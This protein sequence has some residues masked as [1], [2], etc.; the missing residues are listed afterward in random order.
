MLGE[1]VKFCKKGGHSPLGGRLTGDRRSV[2]RP[3]LASNPVLLAQS[4]ACVSDLGPGD[5]VRVECF[6][7][8]QVELLTA[9]MLRTAGLPGYE[10][11]TGLKRR[12]CRDA[13]KKAAWTCRLGGL[14]RPTGPYAGTE[15]K[16][17]RF[18]FWRD[19]LGGPQPSDVTAC[20]TDVTACRTNVVF[21][22]AAVLGMAVLST[23]GLAQ[24]MRGSSGGFHGGFGGGFHGGF[25][26]PGFGGGFARPG[27][28]SRFVEP[29]FRNGFANRDRRADRRDIFRDRFDLRQDFRD[30]RR[31]RRCGTP[32]DIARDRA[33]IRQDRRDLFQDFRDFRQDREGLERNMRWQRR[34]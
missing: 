9:E 4:D 29:G 23:N 16:D 25:A 18:S 12:Q 13:T 17:H 8:G 3:P 31:D 28:Q 26:G 21:V 11:I 32:A 20:R 24:G 19:K 27:F 6:T 7:C 15:P 10:R 14:M 2:D 33:D 34:Q 30:L 22:A 1:C 5:C